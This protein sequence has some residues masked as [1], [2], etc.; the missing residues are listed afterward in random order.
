MYSS[1]R[2]TVKMYKVCFTVQK[3]PLKGFSYE[4]Y[5][6]S[7]AKYGGQELQKE[8]FRNINLF[9]GRRLTD[10]KKTVLSC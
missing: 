5:K 9:H 10:Q 7:F 8:E 1:A 3:L 6:G 2:N 4:V